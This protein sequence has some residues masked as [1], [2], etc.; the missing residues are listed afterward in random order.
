[1]SGVMMIVQP[2]PISP[3]VMEEARE[4]L[5]AARVACGL[6]AL[7]EDDAA[8]EMLLE[9]AYDEHRAARRRVRE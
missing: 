2:L 5:N 1:M 4:R 9:R 7:P 3:E 8:T 6:S